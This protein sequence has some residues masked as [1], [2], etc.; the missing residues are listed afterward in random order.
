MD[1]EWPSPPG[2]QREP[3]S[4]S[5]EG[6]VRAGAATTVVAVLVDEALETEAERGVAADSRAAVGVGVEV[7]PGI[8]CCGC[9]PADDVSDGGLDEDG[10][11]GK[12]DAPRVGS[13][14]I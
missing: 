14:F 3:L 5:G 10:G 8:P 7:D 2:V 1:S 11:E 6:I 4:E 9:A 12:S 13:W